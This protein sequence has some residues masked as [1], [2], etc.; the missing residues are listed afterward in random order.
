MLLTLERVYVYNVQAYV[1]DS[2]RYSIYISMEQTCFICG[3]NFDLKYGRPCMFKVP[4]FKETKNKEFTSKFCGKES[5]ILSDILKSLNLLDDKL[6]SVRNKRS[7]CTSVCKKCAR[8]IVNCGS[9]FQQLRTSISLNCRLCDSSNSIVVGKRSS[10]QSSPSG[11]TPVKKA[12]KHD[13]NSG[14]IVHANARK[15]LFNQEESSAENDK[16]NDAIANLMCLPVQEKDYHSCIVRVRTKV[17][18]LP[19]VANFVLIYSKNFPSDIHCIFFGACDRT[20]MQ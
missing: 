17:V 13:E 2:G 4:L 20:R 15:S 7:T 12:P 5:I 11:F 14:N 16:M 6:L 9:L 18:L 8:T 3:N 10:I 1:Y 19:I